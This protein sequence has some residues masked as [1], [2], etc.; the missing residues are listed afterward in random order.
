MRQNIAMKYSDGKKVYLYSHWKGEE[1]DSQLKQD[2][3]RAIARNERWDDES[4]LAR[5]IISEVIKDDIYGETNYGIAP[6]EMQDEFPT[7][8][9]D[10]KAKTVDGERFADFAN[11]IK[12]ED[13]PF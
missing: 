13:I 2:L 8:E 10:L 11:D 12:A 9:V 7:I 4:Y 1:G 5:I 3:K 6:Y